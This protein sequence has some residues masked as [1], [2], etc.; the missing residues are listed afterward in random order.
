ML[1]LSEDTGHILSLFPLLRNMT[2]I[3]WEKY[4]KKGRGELTVKKAYGAITRFFRAYS[5]PESSEY[6]LISDN[7]YLIKQRIGGV[8]TKNDKAEKLRLERCLRRE[9]YVFSTENLISFYTSHGWTLKT[10]EVYRLSDNICTLLVCAVAE[11]CDRF[12]KNGRGSTLRMRSAIESLRRLPELEINE[13]FSA[14]CPTET[15]FMKVK[16]FADGDDATRDVY[17]EALIRCAR[18]RREDECVLLSR[19][20][21]QCGDGRL[22]ALIAPHSHLPAVMY[23][24]LT[25]VL[26][27]AVSAFSFLMWGWL[28]L[29]AVLPVFEAVYSLGDFVFSRIVKTTPPLRLSPEKL[30]C[31]RE[32]LVVITTLLFGGDK[33][34]GIFERLEEFWLRN[35][36]K[37]LRFGILG[38]FCDCREPKLDG[39]DVIAKNAAEHIKRL[40]AEYGDNF[41]LFLRRRT[42]NS[43]G[44]YGGRERKRGAVVDLIKA[45]RGGEK[46]ET[47]IC[48][49]DMSKIS[50]LLTLDSDTELPIDGAIELL[51]A[52]MHP[53]NMPVLKDGRVVSGYGIF[54][55]AVRTRLADSTRTYH[56]LFGSRSSGVYERA[57]YDRYQT[58]LGSGVFCGKGLIDIELFEKL[59]LSAVPDGI[60]LSHDVIEGG[61]LRTLLV[62]DCTFSDSTP[63][64]SISCFR[65]QHRWVRGDVQNLRFIGSGHSNRALNFR[66]AENLRRLLTPIS[67]AAGLIAAAFFAVPA[68]ALPVFLLTLS[69]YWLPALLG[70]VGTAFS[71]SYT[72]R[73]FFTRCVGVIAQSLEGLLYSLASLAENAAST[74]DAALRALW[75]MYVSHRNLLEWTTFSQTDSG[76]DG[77]ICGYLQNHVASV[78][79]GTL[80]TAF[81]PL[82][83]YRLCGIVWFFFPVLACLLASP[84]RDRTRTATDVQRRT[85]SRYAREIFAFFDENVSHKTHW[86]PPDNLQLSPAECTAYR[87][88]PTNIG[89]YMLSLLAARDFGFIGSAVLAERMGQT[90]GTVSRL[91]KCRGQLYNW[92]DIKT[93]R[94]LGNRYISAVDSGNFVTM[95]VC[96]A[97]GLDEYSHEDIRL[98]E[99]AADCRSIV[100]DADFG[101]FW[102][103]KKHMLYLGCD[104]EGKPQGSICYDMLMSEIRTTC[105]WLCASGRLP[106]KLWQSLSRTITAENG[107]IGMVSWAGSC[108]EYFMP[109]LF[110]KREKDSFIDE[111]LR[112]A[113]SG[114]KHH[115]KNGIFGVSESGY[116]AFDPDM[117]YRYKVHGVPKLALKRYPRGE[118]V[119]SPYSSFLMLGDDPAS[120]LKNLA[121]LEETGCHGKYGFYEALDLT[122]GESV[123]QS[124][125]AHHLGMSLAACA[126]FCFDGINVRRFMKDK[127]LF[128]CRELL[129]ESIPKDAPL[130]I[131]ENVRTFGQ[132][133]RLPS[134][135]EVTDENVS[136]TSPSASLITGGGLTL[137]TS[138]SGHI[139]MKCGDFAVNDAD[140]ALYRGDRTAC[141]TFFEDGEKRA[142]TPLDGNTSFSYEHSGSHFACTSSSA[143]FPASV[144]GTI[145]RGCRTFAFKTR[146]S[147]DR[148]CRVGFSFVPILARQEEYSAHPSF[149]SLFIEAD[150][151]S[152]ERIL[153]FK[154]RGGGFPYCAIALSDTDILPQFTA[155]KDHIYAHS[156]KEMSDVFPLK[157][158]SEGI[159][160]TINPLCAIL[161]PERKG[162]EFV[163]LVTCG[164]SKKECT[165]QLLRAR[166]KRFPRQHTAPPCP[167]ADEMLAKM[168]FSR[169][170]EGLSDVDS[171][172]LWRLSLSGTVPLAVMEVYEET[173]AISRAL[174]AFLRLKTAFV[175]TEL[176]FLVHEKEKY[177]SPLRAFIV[178]QTESEYAPFMHRA[179][180]IA[181]ADADSFSAEELAFLKRYAFDYSESDS[182]EMPG[183]VLPLYVPPKIMGYEPKTVAAEVKNGFSYDASGVVSDEIKEHYMPYS[184]VMAGYAAGTVVTHKTLGFVFWRNARECRV[185]PFDGNPY[186]AYYGIR[187]V[188]GIAGRFFDLAAFSEKTVFEGGKAVYSGSIAGHGYE[189]KVYARTKLPAVE[190]RLKFDGISPTC[191]LIKEQSADMTAENKGGVWLFSDMRHRAVPFVGF[192]KCSEKCETVNDSALLFCGVD[193]QRRDILAFSCT[194]DE[195]SFAIGGAPGREAALRVASLCCRGD[196]SGEAEAFVKKHIPGYRLQSGNA[197]LDA[198][199][200]HFAPYQTAI[201]RFFGK[202]GFYQTGGA[203]GFRDQLQDC[204]CLVYSSPE[205]VRVHILRCCA[206]QYREGDVMH[207]WF[208]A[209][210]GDTGI[211]TKCSD[212]FLYLP[213]AVADYIE[214]TGD[215]DILNVRIGY[216]ESLPPES[217][218]RYEAPARS[219]SRE[220]VYMHCIRALANGEKT[221][222]HGLSL[223]GSCDW[224]DGMSR[225]GSGGRGE[226]VFTSWL[227]VLVCRE[228]LPVMKLME[229]YRSIAHFT[230]VSAGLV[231]ALERNAFDGDRYIRAYDDAGR[232]IGG[233]NSPE[234]SVD[235]LG[236][237]FAAMTLGRTERTVSGLDTAYRAL[238]D[239]KAKLF[240]LFDP[241]FDRYDAGYITSYCPG[242]RENGGQYTHGALWGV[243][244]FLRG[245]ETAKALEILSAIMP[246]SHTDEKLF[247]AE[248]Y[249]ITADI[250]GGSRAGR[251]G[252]SWY[253]GSAS[254]FFVIMLEEILGIR[255]TNGFSV[256]D[257]K[258]LTDYTVTLP[259]ERGT[260]TVCVSSLFHETTLDGEPTSFPLFLT[261]GDHR[262]EVKFRQTGKSVPTGSVSVPVASRDETI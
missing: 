199:F 256:I 72:P 131:G 180:G 86:L 71:R 229:D 114:Q 238:F 255:L 162:G 252:W 119:V 215:A 186:A 165:E 48:P 124:Y 112:F 136:L 125:M 63:K 141:F 24:L 169:P 166:R 70:L 147:G 102:N 207:W 104:G 58:L 129:S 30:P 88:S 230:A 7:L 250:Y 84:V 208:R 26:A 183:A 249:V 83:L 210:Q 79:A 85:V 126:N 22:L 5:L 187:I 38:D 10:A 23:Y 170:S 150:Y 75:R 168:L 201:S 133:R 78:F 9:G 164:G 140:F 205:T 241:P 135:S 127:R 11:E 35:E 33:D 62:S 103:P 200:S 206:H 223:M 244:G 138:S 173:S 143:A 67:A 8:R 192:M 13:V 53:E 214:K 242:L 45:L 145:Y 37:G 175:K 152:T 235:I 233:R 251:G 87:T 193:A 225:I 66:L 220:S 121:A 56:A 259:L 122:D 65:R 254:W 159:G 100:R 68:S 105:Y 46:P 17:R 176:L 228:F 115:R 258:P 262:I 97:A 261:E 194:T 184:Y 240:R 25:T 90:I 172:C 82:P 116:F 191:M 31:E 59:A 47:F 178:E 44:I 239:R 80:M 118:F 108:F 34:D 96:V 219:E 246:Y 95:L 182:I 111:S 137:I 146:C 179:G 110:L 130:Y 99:L 181:V 197:G 73:R 139:A 4:P 209:P 1:F 98:A 51:S 154:R 18:R 203:F 177:S 109:E 142:F 243:L 40:N 237:A 61:L 101:M 157:I 54:Q 174:R 117:N 156:V 236:Q 123:V 15:L 12:M 91:E 19:M 77:S 212:D 32:T 218:E 216:M 167:E 155:C 134:V 161:T 196:T 188:A 2:P 29:F 234:C 128:A 60:I 52:A 198:L 185:T 195:A 113:L 50:Y 149:S 245:G 226:S 160:A 92:Y 93:L 89:F 49:F 3:F 41:A 74:A 27:V 144:V 190:Y 6:T 224:N 43:S 81:S 28:S 260:V 20:T 69:E 211:R 36:H 257:V 158:R 213:W 163:F 42:K 171:S 151:D 14:L 21:E 107:Y 189:L 222:S 106:K 132:S 64:N 248:P 76:R 153:H 55:P 247:C 217:G 204:F 16:G 232:V 231:L 39:D 94:P 148:T 221:G 227:Y 253:T 120:C 202:T 57:S